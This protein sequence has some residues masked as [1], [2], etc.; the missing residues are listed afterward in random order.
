MKID[1]LSIGSFPDATNAELANRFAVSHYARR[2]APHALAADLKDRIRGI[3]TEATHGVDSALIA[4]L[5]KLEMIAIFGVGTDFIDL[6]AARERNIPVTNTPGILTDEVADLAIGLM[7]ASARQILFADR[8]VRDGS[9][10]SKG[11]IRLGRTGAG[12][13]MGLLGHGGVEGLETEPNPP[14]EVLKLSNVIVQ[15]HHGSGTVET[16]AAI[17]RLMVDNLSAHFAGQ[18]LLTPVR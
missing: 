13:T 14:P 17:G 4:A 18:P 12:K 7:L 5:P 3:A 10:A 6:A 9:W 11:P 8:Y 2:P 15:P 1:V 16:R